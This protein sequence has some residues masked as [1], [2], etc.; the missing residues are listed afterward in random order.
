MPTISGGSSGGI[1]GVT[2]SGTPAASQALI[3]TGAAAASWAY[4]PGFEIGRDTITGNVA[5]ASTTEA[6]GTTIISCAAHTFDG[7]AVLVELFAP[8]V[9]TPGAAVGNAVD[10]CLFES[11]T[12]ISR[13]ARC[14]T[15]SVAAAVSSVLTGKYVFTPTAGSHTY[16]ITAFATSLTG[17]PTV[18]AGT[19]SGAAFAPAFVR[20]TKV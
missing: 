12:E 16:T 13:I 6:T 3:A 20:F 11:T 18:I 10:A 15:Q 9:Q 4:P 2:V 8:A 17:S 1:P 14:I 19:G 7:G 5:I